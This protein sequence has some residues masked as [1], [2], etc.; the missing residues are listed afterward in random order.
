MLGPLAWT[1]PSASLQPAFVSC[2]KGVCEEAHS[3]LFSSTSKLVG[4]FSPS[5]P[6]SPLPSSAPITS[7]LVKVPNDYEFKM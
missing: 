5:L 4:G 6:G 3:N 1:L 7:E 2:R